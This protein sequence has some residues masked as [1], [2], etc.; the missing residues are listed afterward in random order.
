MACVCSIACTRRAA[1]PAPVQ[2]F[3]SHAWRTPPL[4]ALRRFEEIATIAALVA[5]FLL[6]RS[7][8]RVAPKDVANSSCSCR[9]VANKTCQRL[10]RTGDGKNGKELLRHYVA[11]IGAFAKAGQPEKADACFQEISAARLDPDLFAYT[12][13]I[14][15]HARTGD[16][17][18]AQKWFQDLMD[19]ALQPDT[20]CY[21]SVLNACAQAGAAQLAES[22]LLKMGSAR[23]LVNQVAYSTVINA[24]AQ[25]GDVSSAERW[26]TGMIQDRISPNTVTF[27][28][29][30]KA[31]A[32]NGDVEHA[33]L[34]LE[35]LLAAELDVPPLAFNTAINACAATGDVTSAEQLLSDM[36]RH[37]VEDT[38][39]TYNSLVKVSTATGDMD[40]AQ[41]WFDMLLARRLHPDV[42]TF[43]SLLSCGAFRGDVQAC[44]KWYQL[45]GTWRVAPDTITYSTMRTACARRGDYARAQHWLNMIVRHDD[46]AR[47]MWTARGKTATDPFS[48]TG[49]VMKRAL[50]RFRSQ[51]DQTT[52]EHLERALEY[53]WL[54]GYPRVPDYEKQL[55]HGAYKYM[56]GM[57]P[58]TAREIYR[59]IPES[60]TVLDTFCGSGTVLVEG[61]VAGKQK[62]IGSDTSPLAVFVSTH[63][64]DAHRLSLKSFVEEAEKVAADKGL[65]W[66]SLR[67]RIRSISQEGVTPE[68]RDGLWFAYAVAWRLARSPFVG[69][70]PGSVKESEAG[71]AR[72]YFLST[73]HRFAHQVRELRDELCGREQAVELHCCDCRKLV[74]QQEVDAI[75]TSPPYPGVYDYFKAAAADCRE[76]AGE[77][78]GQGHAEDGGYGGLGFLAEC[79]GAVGAGI[80]GFGGAGGTSELGAASL[81]PE[82]LS[83][84]RMQWQSQQ[85]EWLSAAFGNLRMGGTLTVMVGN[86]DALAEN[87]NE[88]DCLQST[89]DAA[90]ALGFK[91]VASSTIESCADDAHQTKGMVR[92]EHMIHFLKPAEPAVGQPVQAE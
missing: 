69:D 13:M 42:Q 38:L 21:S 23:V 16:V 60:K 28:S 59:L 2:H 67:D 49:S 44:E 32:N 66:T 10:R 64:T 22:W 68:L 9:A 45:L 84:A 52:A 41:R 8:R 61:L 24:F 15:A 81:Q 19:A 89:L 18:G 56:A 6:P 73:V 7:V 92:T 46:K 43:N 31:A 79:V 78:T 48:E 62:C 86:G 40:S 47:D 51:G 75:I 91:L 12:G 88:I 4:G 37:F 35:R 50:Y 53:Q 11:A 83:Q 26:F 80:R 55:T 1:H 20:V 25:E 17:A 77:A 5:G 3:P 30:I 39:V 90:A 87:A 29:M 58:M 65:G 33:R 63:H 74:L 36:R 85:E 54:Y 34:W 57:Q 71:D 72:A 14:N 76:V 70:D 27:C 82:S